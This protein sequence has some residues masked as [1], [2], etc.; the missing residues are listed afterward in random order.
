MATGFLHISQ[1]EG[2]YPEQVLEWSDLPRVQCLL[3]TA[4]H[5]ANELSRANRKRPFATLQPSQGLGQAVSSQEVVQALVTTSTIEVPQAEH[6]PAKTLA[7]LTAMPASAAEAALQSAGLS[8]QVSSHLR[9]LPAGEACH[10]SHLGFSY[11]TPLLQV[12][13]ATRRAHIA[14][15]I[16]HIRSIVSPLLKMRGLRQIPSVA[17]SGLVF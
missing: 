11:D 7:A 4:V 16:K 17:V 13:Y 1:L 3:R 9:S 14:A 8:L 5:R 15:A 2:V 12:C 6:G 10:Q